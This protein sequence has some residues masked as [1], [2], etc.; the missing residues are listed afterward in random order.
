M[1]NYT[2]DVLDAG[3]GGGGV[4]SI[5]REGEGKERGRGYPAR[6]FDLLPLS[7]LPFCLYF[8]LIPLLCA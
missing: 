1:A 2:E 7:G 5:Q 6:L 8:S 3:D 4:L